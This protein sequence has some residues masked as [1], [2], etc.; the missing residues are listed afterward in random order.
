MGQSFCC[1]KYGN[2]QTGHQ[3]SCCSK[4]NGNNDD[5]L[6]D[7]TMKE[8]LAQ[9]G[10]DSNSLDVRLYGAFSVAGTIEPGIRPGDRRQG[11]A[12][13]KPFG[14]KSIEPWTDHTELY[15]SSGSSIH[16]HEYLRKVAKRGIYGKLSEEFCKVQEVSLNKDCSFAFTLVATTLR[17]TLSPSNGGE[18]THQSMYPLACWHQN[19]GII[20]DWLSL[21]P[22]NS[23]FEELLDVPILLHFG[24]NN[25]MLNPVTDDGPGKSPWGTPDPSFWKLHREGPFGWRVLSSSDLFELEGKGEHDLTCM[26]TL[27]L[28]SG[29]IYKRF[30]EC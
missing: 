4:E 27:I 1:S 7:G 16:M 9:D 8:S 21:N 11:D 14:E 28:D 19:Y 6:L 18:M 29:R 12:L 2:G 20:R 24:K 25:P 13:P 5:D 30:S 22:R 15:Q 26:A 10:K 3:L 23:R 17:A